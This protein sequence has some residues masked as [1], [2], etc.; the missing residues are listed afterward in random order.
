[1]QQSYDSRAIFPYGYQNFERL[2]KMTVCL[3]ASLIG[4]DTGT[5]A[6]HRWLRW[7]SVKPIAI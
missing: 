6:P 7:R 2:P 1:M 5:A 3:T 4:G